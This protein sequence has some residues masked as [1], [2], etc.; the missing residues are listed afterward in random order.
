MKIID[1]Y[2]TSTVQMSGKKSAHEECD[3]MNINM[4]LKTVAM[5]SR[6]RLCEEINMTRP[7]QHNCLYPGL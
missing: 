3:K 5:R 2:F 1:K 7:V 6:H 4:K